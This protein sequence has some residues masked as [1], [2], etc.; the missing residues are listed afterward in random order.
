MPK[1][2]RPP[3]SPQ[4]AAAPPAP[5]FEFELVSLEQAREA[6]E[7]PPA[8]VR[9]VRRMT[10]AQWVARRRVLAESERRPTRS[11][12]QWMLSLP[13]ELRPIE[14]L[15]RYARVANQ[16]AAHWHD[17]A[18]CTRQLEELVLDRRGGRQG[19]PPAVAAELQ[20]LQ[21]YWQRKRRSEPR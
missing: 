1:D 10:P 18:E 21:E 3:A 17:P 5:E 4:P 7:E 13:A 12:T 15:R 20:R 9:A 8:G 11:A 2:N 16:L 14:L 19:F 6:L